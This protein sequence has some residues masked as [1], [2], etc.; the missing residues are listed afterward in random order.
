M[1]KQQDELL[2]ERL[3]KA[4]LRTYGIPATKSYPAASADRAV[5][6]ARLIGYPVVLKL[7]SPQVTFKTEVGGVAVNLTT[8]VGVR[9]HYKQIVEN[10]RSQ[11]PDAKIE[12]VTVQKMIVARSGFELI[13]GCKR[14]P[15]LGSILMVGAGGIATRIICDC[16]LGLPPLNERLARR[17]L[18]SLASWP[19]LLGYR[20]KPG[21]DVDSVIDVLMRLSYLVADYP[22]IAELDINP[23]LVSQSGVMALDARIRIDHDVEMDS[24]RPYSH[25]AIRPYPDELVQRAKLRDGTPIILRPIRPEDEPAWQDLLKRCSDESIR[26]RFRAILK[27]SAHEVATRYCFVDYD[28]EMAIVAEIDGADRTLI[29]GMGNLFAEPD[30]KSAEYA[31]LVADDWQRRG[32]GTLLTNFCL[33][34]AT[35]WGRQSVYAETTYSNYRMTSLFEKL[36]FQSRRQEDEVLLTKELDPSKGLPGFRGDA[37]QRQREE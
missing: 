8:E 2:P 30:G 36:G 4:L 28:R 31:V 25:L 18:E 3:C 15:T 10:A 6:L 34:I 35:Q 17:M 9:S 22:E 27:R 14:D 12:G 29:I 21:V 19:L 26:L 20:G 37:S 5:E 23:L 32:L 24:S 16:A 13:M 1:L 7:R 33:R 11:R